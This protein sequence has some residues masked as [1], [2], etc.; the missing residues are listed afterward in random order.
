MRRR[1][2][3]GGA[4]G[5]RGGSKVVGEVGADGAGSGGEAHGAFGGGE[6]NI[7]LLFHVAVGI[8]FGDFEGLGLGAGVFVFFEDKG[9]AAETGEGVEGAGVVERVVGELFFAQ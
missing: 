4:R 7:A 2:R 5:R 3:R 8:A 1:C 9:F 6:K